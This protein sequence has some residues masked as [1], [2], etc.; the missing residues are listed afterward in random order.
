MT[1]GF[2]EMEYLLDEMYNAFTPTPLQPGDPAYVD[3]REVRGDKDVIEDL[4]RT[5]RRSQLQS[6]SQ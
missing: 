6:D 4:G 2:Q 1:I 3:C 5:V